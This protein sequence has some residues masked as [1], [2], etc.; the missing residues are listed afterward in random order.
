MKKL[1]SAFL[2]VP[3]T[4]RPLGRI[5]RFS[6][7]GILLVTMVL[8]LAPLTFPHGPQVVVGDPLEGPGGSAW[9]GTDDLGRDLLVRTLVGMRTTW[10]AV[11]PVILGGIVI[12]GVIGAIAGL[13][14]GWLDN[15]LM[16]LTDVTLA[17][18]GVLVTIAVAA[19]LGPGL[20][21]TLLAISFTFWTPYARIVRGE[22]RRI[23]ASPHIEAAEMGGT[24]GARLVTRHIGPGLSGPVIVQAS[25]DVSTVIMTLASLSFLGLGTPPPAPEL[26]A[27]TAKSA[28][29]VFS[30]WWVP[31]IPALGVVILSVLGNFFGD[32][33]TDLNNRRAGR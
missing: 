21:N 9:L 19:A 8:I 3:D 5:E 16:R 14:G 13:S 30:A 4:L 6:C 23:L 33:M 29:F 27:M 17:L 32:A 12:G 2:Y 15:I 22:V 1:W 26:G 25:L 11:F 10:F 7:Y 18:P 20:R 28:Q 24:H 31:L